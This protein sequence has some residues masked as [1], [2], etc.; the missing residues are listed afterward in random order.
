[1]TPF[2]HKLLVKKL[3]L[4]PWLP[5]IRQLRLPGRNRKRQG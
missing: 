4:H 1:M 5:T 2:G 3:Y